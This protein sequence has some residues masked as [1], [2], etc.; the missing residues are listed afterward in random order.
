MLGH[1]ESIGPMEKNIKTANR[2][3]EI[4]KETALR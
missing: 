1:P 3:R 4:N 2:P